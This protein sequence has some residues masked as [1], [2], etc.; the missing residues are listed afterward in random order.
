MSTTPDSRPSPTPGPPSAAPA[1]RPGAGAG[2]ILSTVAGGMVALLAVA[3]LIGGGALIWAN[4]QKDADG[5]IAS[6]SD[7]FSTST[8]AIATENLDVDGDIPSSVAT[9]DRYG[10]VRLRATSR[11]DKPV[12][13]GIARTSDVSAYLGQS[14][15]ATVTDLDYDPF[16]AT[17]RTEGGTRRP[18]P[19]TAQRIWAA[20]ANGSGTQEVTWD[21][22]HGDWSIVVM[23]A[24]GSRG[25]DAGV[26]AGANVPVLDE[27][28]WGTLGGGLLLLVAGGGLMYLGLRAPRPRRRA[29]A[30]PDLTPAP[31]A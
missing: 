1:S 3:L 29:P 17:Y 6:G 23:N 24:D 7:R 31:A 28:A 12:F 9:P 21:V 25:V 5:Y 4:G 20:S 13:V 26:S 10:K 16:R 27:V 11:A 22:K 30:G 15:R 2:R 14:P 18:A 19:P 8:Y